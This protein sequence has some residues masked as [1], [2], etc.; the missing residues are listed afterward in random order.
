MVRRALCWL[1]LVLVVLVGTA[2][3]A[4]AHVDIDPAEA[5]AGSTTTVTFSFQHGKDGT[6]TTGLEVKLPEGASVVDVPDVEGWTSDVDEGEG[7]ITWLGGPVPDGV[8]AE[9]PVVVQM[10]ATPGVVLFPTVQITEG[11]ELAWIA[12]GE[13]E[14]EDANPAPRLTLTADPDAATS[15]T[16]TTEATTSTTVAETTTTND[17][18]GTV[19]EAEERDDGDQSVAPWVIGSGIAAL[20]AIGV[21]GMLLKRR[22]D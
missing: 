7:I 16:T 15:T 5:V 2:L 20:V 3:P 18:P 19:L 8:R 21:G 22:M 4:G 13:G 9:L 10:P 12:E 14:S 11:G 6:A 17:L 1:G